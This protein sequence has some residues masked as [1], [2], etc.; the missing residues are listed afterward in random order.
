[1]N[2]AAFQAALD[3]IV[4]RHET[5]RTNFVPE[6]D[7]A[8]QVVRPAR[9]L[10]IAWVDLSEQ[11]EGPDRERH[12]PEVLSREAQRPFD[13]VNDSL[14]RVSIF[15]L[16]E[17]EHVLL[18]NLHHIICDEWSLRVLVR[19]L[20]Q[21]YAAALA[22]EQL[23]LSDLPIQYGDYAVWQRDWLRGPVL[24][25][26]L[27]Y[28]KERLKGD[29]L[30]QLPLDHPRST[31]RAHSGGRRSVQV[32]K[33]IADAL[34]QL[35]RREGVTLFMALLAT[36]KAL[37]ARYADQDVITVGSPIAGRTRI[38]T[39]DLI[40]FFVNTLVLR[41]DLSGDPTYLEILRR[42]RDVTLGAYDHAELPFE[43][44][45]EALH[46][47]RE[48]SRAPLIQV[49]FA[50]EQ[51]FE[52]GLN[53]PGVQARFID[54]DTQTAKF[55]LTC[56]VRESDQELWLCLEYAAALFDDDT[57]VR[58]L[59]HWQR[60]LESVTASPNL[61]LSEIPLL[62][63]A[64]RNQILVEWNQ[65]KRSIPESATLAGLFEAQVQRGPEVLAARYGA[66]ELS[67]QELN[68]RSNRLAHR[69]RAAGAGPD[70]LVGLCTERSLD[71]IVGMVGIIKAGAAYLPLDPAYPKERL[72]L[73]LTDA[74]AGL[75]ITSEH[76][77]A[78]LPDTGAKVIGLDSSAEVPDSNLPPAAQSGNLACVFYTSGS[79]GL[80]KGV[81]VTQRGILRLVSNTD[82]VQLVA[83]DRVA[84]LANPCFDAA[85][86]EIWGA[87][88]NGAALIGL[89]REQALSPRT[90]SLE[91]SR[92]RI[93]TLFLTTALFNQVAEEA[94]GAFHGLKHLLF[95]GEAVDP[96]RVRHVLAH[97]PPERLLHVYG[98]TETT[99]FATW[100]LVTDVP[101]DAGTVPIGR[102]IANT[103]VY[104]LDRHMEPVPV[105]LVGQVYIGGPGVA[106]G[107]LHRGELTAQKFIADPFSNEPGARL[108]KTGDMARY[109]PDGKI[110]FIGRLDDQVKIRGFRVELG[111]VEAAIS[112]HPAVKENVT[113]LRNG[114]AALG[115]RLVGFVVLKEGYPANALGEVRQ[116]LKEKLPAYM[117][118]SALVPLAKL[119][120]NA[121]GKVDRH[122]LPNDNAIRPEL[123]SRF[124]A[125][126]TGVENKMAA[127][128]KQVL[129][130]SEVG[131]QDNFF[132][133]GGHSMLAVRLFSEMEKAFGKKLPLAALFQRP[134]IAGLLELIETEGSPRSWS[135]LVDIQPQGSRPPMFWIHSLGGDGG[136]AFFYY[137][138]LA[139]LLGADQPSFG[140]R[141]PQEPFT[142]IEEMARHYVE[143]LIRACPDGP[144]FLGGF[145]FGGVVAYEM[146]RQLH[147]RGR[148]VG[149]L[150][151][152]ECAPPNQLPAKIQWRPEVI[153]ALAGNLH[154][155]VADLVQQGPTELW[156]RLARKAKSVQKAVQRRL[157]GSEPGE[158]PPALDN[159]IDME[160]Y[161]KDYIRYA[162]AHWQ[163]LLAY[164]PQPYAGRVVLFRARKQPLLSLDPS[165]GWDRLAQEGVAVNVIPGTHENMLEEPNVHILAAELEACLIE[166][167]R[168]AA[169]PAQPD[170]SI[171]EEAQGHVSDPFSVMT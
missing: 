80:P 129:G 65:T 113:L 119:P 118:P 120:L 17:G 93:T 153:G 53:L 45:V 150:A 101:E 86:F 56:V 117:V 82:Y 161:P 75:V 152:L 99:T 57:A 151:L 4:A 146:A 154:S 170:L 23:A 163:A 19:E 78:R 2:R 36:W 145:C 97:Q 21:L 108:Y 148:G 138:K 7:T 98:P 85:T 72:H 31:Q 88:V 70:K 162:E 28:W 67:Y 96:K 48:A 6:G 139:G 54:V 166:A 106:R 111:E 90:L 62:S 125:P 24:A 81:M 37:L 35:S 59:S 73:M 100:N 84:Q 30:L 50:L 123:T 89:A 131:V 11:I 124:V 141:S 9:P 134:T 109:R 128:W 66:K 127:V 91:L 156:A 135:L 41:T 44:L 38:E 55:D 160:H 13:L 158:A 68:R 83:S 126:R 171:A 51:N 147:S 71:L 104:I 116:F 94:P 63:S 27:D 32:P 74:Q 58:M 26:E 61:R 112:A 157:G 87:L 169:D 29:H 92:E 95:G 39:E 42:V 143:E 12:L 102:P 114:D 137:R 1:L 5:L 69:L 133:L 76:L 18:L 10:P 121:N 149:L 107:Y 130:L 64:E 165:L 25:Q 136:G 142:R 132:D 105:G 52:N 110:E 34:K 60:L 47:E 79:T 122:A 3:Q 144:Y 155:W 167:Q 159:L 140:I 103:S 40:G 16:E 22:G 168:L 77:R 15:R 8:V 14:I 20:S 33:G 164:Q 43:K 115:Q 46:P 49:L